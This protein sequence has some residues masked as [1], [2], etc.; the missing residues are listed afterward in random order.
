MITLRFFG[1]PFEVVFAFIDEISLFFLRNKVLRFCDIL[2][3][4][5]SVKIGQSFFLLLIETPVIDI[6][7]ITT[8]IK[9][10]FLSG[11][12]FIGILSQTLSP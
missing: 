12:P 2:I 4:L 3:I 7:T 10:D 9:Q 5:E 6:K 1:E 11:W 8:N